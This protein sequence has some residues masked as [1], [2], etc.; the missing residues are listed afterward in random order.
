MNSRPMTQ[1]ENRSRGVKIQKA[2][3]PAGKPSVT[4]YFNDYGTLDDVGNFEQQY[5]S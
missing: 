3:V 5:F 2:S 4:K 1:M